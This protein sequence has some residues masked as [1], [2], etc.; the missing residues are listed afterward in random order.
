MQFKEKI[1]LV[2]ELK[3]K[4]NSTNIVRLK[5]NYLGLLGWQFNTCIEGIIIGREAIEFK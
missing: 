4:N 3:H 1:K 2:K 5:Q